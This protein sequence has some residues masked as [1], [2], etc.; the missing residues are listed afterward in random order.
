MEKLSQIVAYPPP[1]QP[2]HAGWPNK[3]VLQAQFTNFGLGDPEP[4]KKKKTQM[5][6]SSAH[7]LVAQHQ[8]SLQSVT[9]RCL[10]L[11][12]A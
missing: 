4:K 9:I 7:A 12:I 3:H 8:F 5:Y 2:L 10:L 11:K 1:Q 6:K